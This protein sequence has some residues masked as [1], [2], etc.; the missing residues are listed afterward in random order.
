M[1]DAT[2]ISAAYSDL[3]SLATRQAMGGMELTVGQDGSSSDVKLFLQ[4]TNEAM[5]AQPSS[6]RTVENF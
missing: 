6:P 2:S 5:Y 3:V 4:N 1:S